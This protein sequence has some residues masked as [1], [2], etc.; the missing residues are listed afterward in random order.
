[1]SADP[2]IKKALLRPVPALVA[3]GI[4]AALLVWLFVFFVPQSHKLGAL[5]SEQAKLTSVIAKD[6]A[7]VAK[8]KKESKHIG[9]IKSID[10]SLRGYVPAHEDLYGYI[11]TLNQAAKAAGV[12]ITS[13][14]P[15]TLAAVTGTSYTAIAITA[16]VRGTYPQLVAFLHG[17][18]G[19]PRLTD[20]NG[21]TLSGG[22]PGSSGTTTI[23]SEFQLAIFTSQ[24]LPTAPTTTTTGPGF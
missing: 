12:S 19:L 17:I 22:G 9:Q 8:L 20:V 16:T 11:R 5:H 21:L 24:Q 18:Y 1:M 10:S 6:N 7:R 15:H 13:L 3:L 2:N 14:T 23:T 4:V